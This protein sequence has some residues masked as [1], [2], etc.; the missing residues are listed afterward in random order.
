M[1]FD[2]CQ[3]LLGLTLIAPMISAVHSKKPS[4]ARKLESAGRMRGA[5]FISGALFLFVFVPIA[6]L[7]RMLRKKLLK[8]EFEPE[9]KTYWASRQINDAQASSMKRQF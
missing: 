8:L 6:F 9:A 2:L 4:G 1:S 3:R 5:P 7:L